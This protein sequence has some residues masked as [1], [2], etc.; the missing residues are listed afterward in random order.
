[1]SR[2]RIKA[3]RMS[4]AAKARAQRTHGGQVFRE[5][6]IDGVRVRI[7]AGKTDAEVREIVRRWKERQAQAPAAPAETQETAAA[8]PTA[9]PD[10]V[11]PEINPTE[12]DPS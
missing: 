12:G 11:A 9:G 2:L 5:Q 4:R 1:M 10:T 7:P 6:V 8:M 3:P